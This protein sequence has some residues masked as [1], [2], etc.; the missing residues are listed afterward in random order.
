MLLV[1]QWLI[2]A[3]CGREFLWDAGEQSWYLSKKLGNAPRH[4]K[5]CRE[6]RRDERLHQPRQYSKV[7]CDNCGSPVYVPF[8]P[9]GIKPVY[10]RPCL[11]SQR[12]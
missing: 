4:C 3:D 9:R 11:D 10:C 1:D 5:A 8:V 6:R 7:N 2:C 12:T